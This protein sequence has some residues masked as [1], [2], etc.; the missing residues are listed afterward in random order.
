MYLKVTGVLSKNFQYPVSGWETNIWVS[1]EFPSQSFGYSITGLIMLRANQLESTGGLCWIWT[2]QICTNRVNWHRRF[3]LSSQADKRI[4]FLRR[5]LI[6][7]TR[8]IHIH[9]QIQFVW[10]AACVPHF[11]SLDINCANV[12]K[13]INRLLSWLAPTHRHSPP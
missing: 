5:L 7:R 11:W 3:S 13:P 4:I 6:R 12:A 9:I 10:Q 8:H 1:N 2:L